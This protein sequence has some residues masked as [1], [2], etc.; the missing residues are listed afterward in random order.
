[1]TTRHTFRCPECEEG[2][3]KSRLFGAVKAGAEHSE[4]PCRRCG[5]ST[6]LHFSFDFAIDASHKIAV[7]LASF[8]PHPPEDWRDTGGRTVTF[9]SFLI[10]TKR[11]G[12]A[13]AVWL[14]YWHVIRDGEKKISSMDSGR[15]S[16]TWSCSKIYF[17][18]RAM[19]AFSTVRH[20][21]PKG[22]F[23]CRICRIGLVQRRPA[24][25]VS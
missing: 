23:L 20:D 1:V 2:P 10:V 5:A 3:R 15:H 19:L 21:C 14:P 18:Q 13:R 17:L 9:Y 6:A 16:W 8:Y 7:V 24:A 12:R 11:E 22:L 25:V 4:A